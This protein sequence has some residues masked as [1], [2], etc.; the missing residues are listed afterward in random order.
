[1][2]ITGSSLP[3]EFVLVGT[4][5]VELYERGTRIRAAHIR[6]IARN[7][8]QA[9]DGFARRMYNFVSSCP[10]LTIS[11]TTHPTILDYNPSIVETGSASFTT[12]L[13]G[14]I[15]LSA[16]RRR[17]RLSVVYAGGTVRFRTRPL[18]GAF[19]AWVVGPTHPPFNPPSDYLVEW[20]PSE[21]VFTAGEEV[22]F[23]W[24]FKASAGQVLYVQHIS[25][26]EADTQTSD[27]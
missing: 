23:E 1:M 12:R 10:R 5:G 9:I 24:A 6:H 25:G 7:S 20:Q 27:L 19:S 22:V 11:S 16:A 13:D 26:C 3:R 14:K 21:L 8:N 2:T 18:S 15:T 4:Y 17:I